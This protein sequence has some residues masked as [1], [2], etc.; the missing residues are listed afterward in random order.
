[1]H[2]PKV[3][4]LFGYWIVT[5]RSPTSLGVSFKTSPILIPPLAISSRMSRFLIFLVL[6]MT[7]SM[8]SFSTRSQWMGLPGR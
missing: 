7:S 1:M 3:L 2:G 4:P 8:V 6:K 5:F